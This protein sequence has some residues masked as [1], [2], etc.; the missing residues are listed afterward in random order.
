M[1]FKVWLDERRNRQ[2]PLTGF[3]RSHLRNHGGV[4]RR[5]EWKLLHNAEG[6][7]NQIHIPP[8]QSDDLAEAKSV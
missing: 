1:P 2:R 7:F 4:C 3:Y 8:P 6:I 5:I